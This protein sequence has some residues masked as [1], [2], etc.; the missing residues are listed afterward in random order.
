M[1]AGSSKDDGY[2]NTNINKLSPAQSTPALQDISTL[3][4]PADIIDIFS[5]GE[6]RVEKSVCSPQVTIPETIKEMNT[7]FRR[8]DFWDLWFEDKRYLWL[9]EY[10]WPIRNYRLSTRKKKS[11]K[12]LVPFLPRVSE[13][14]NWFCEKWIFLVW[15]WAKF[16][17]SLPH[18]YYLHFPRFIILGSQRSLRKLYHQAS[19]VSDILLI[20]TFCAWVFFSTFLFT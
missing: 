2:S 16:S 7:S 6:K 19:F 14:G 15:N 8:N 11:Q 12:S 18:W 5:A 1:P 4:S 17:E 3:V 20:D 10:R 9:L 13:E